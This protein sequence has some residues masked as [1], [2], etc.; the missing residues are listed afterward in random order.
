MGNDRSLSKPRRTDNTKYGKANSNI[1]PQSRL[2]R[3]PANIIT[4]GSDEVKS[5]FPET[6]GG[7]F[8]QKKATNSKS[9]IFKG[10][11]GGTLD[12]RR[13]TDKGNASRFFYLAKAGKTERNE[14]LDDFEAR[15]LVFVSVEG[16]ASGCPARSGVLSQALSDVLDFWNLCLGMTSS[17]TTTK[18]ERSLP[19]KLD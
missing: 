19:V 10:L 17:D 4:D 1:N 5:F 8:P 7:G 9:M 14:G 6:S 11:D 2:G 18:R 12:V 3:H 13:N 15:F 16:A